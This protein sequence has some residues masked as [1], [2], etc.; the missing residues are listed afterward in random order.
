MV[1]CIWREYAFLN[2]KQNMKA[3]SKNMILHLLSKE[4]QSIL[5]RYSSALRSPEPGLRL[6]QPKICFTYPCISGW[7]GGVNI[8]SAF[9][10]WASEAAIVDL[11]FTP[12]YNFRGLL[13]GTKSID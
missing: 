13:K 12:S 7:G 8:L 4:V 10:L 1:I 11:Y 9:L 6:E 5:S 3:Y 2:K